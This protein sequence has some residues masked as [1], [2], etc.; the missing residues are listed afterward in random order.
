MKWAIVTQYWPVREQ[1]YRG[2]SAFQ[3]IRC[4]AN[5]VEVQ[6]FA[7]Q[8]RY[9]NWLAPRNRPWAKTDSTF[10]PS[11][12]RT[13]YFDYPALPVVSRFFNGDICASKL[14]PLIRNFAPDLILNYWVYPDGYA[15]VKV[16]KELGIPVVT[17]A[18]GTDLNRSLS[19]FTRRLT[20]WALKNSDLVV[21]VSQGLAERAV[22]LGAP[23]N[24]VTA[25]LN[26]C[27][28]A[29][30]FPTDKLSSRSSVNIDGRDELIL[31]VGR[32]DP[33]KGLLELVQAS[34][35]LSSSRPLLRLVMVGEGPARRPIEELAKELNFSSRLRLESPCPSAKVAEWMNAADVFALPSYAEGC[36]NVLV[37][38]L[39]CGT[40][41]VASNVGGIPELV[42]PERA[43]LVPARQVPALREALDQA[44]EKTWNY[45]LIASRSRRSWTDT[46][47]DLYT[48]CADL[49]NT[50]K[51]LDPGTLH[52]SATSR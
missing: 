34:A 29:I 31:Y 1:P 52:A 12:I 50:S 30:F 18:I 40:P 42:D 51:S 2:H 33:L 5:S 10:Q 9:P 8:S 13:T 4:L 49:I 25:I 28:N 15:A 37:E 16:G 43:I 23:R 19:G 26:G 27:D 36:P 32:L 41:V 44:L 48:V 17:T 20:E 38:A 22:A 24:N 46:A 35:Q 3:T 45:D 21:T 39:N 7:P 11:D 14:K 6:A 47:G